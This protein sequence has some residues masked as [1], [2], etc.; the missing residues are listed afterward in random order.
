MVHRL[1]NRM[2]SAFSALLTCLL[3]PACPQSDPQGGTEAGMNGAGGSGGVMVSPVV[4]DCELP[5]PGTSCG[6][7]RHCPGGISAGGS[8][9][10]GEPEVDPVCQAERDPVE[11]CIVGAG[12]AGNPFRFSRSSTTDGGQYGTV[13][14]VVVGENGARSEARHDYED[15]CA[16]VNAELHGPADLSDC[17]DFACVEDRFRGA[18]TQLRCGPEE[19]CGI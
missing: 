12:R 17:S 3:L 4:A 7:L 16:E 15:L 8:S 6:V 18:H 9:S 11:A 1:P 10:G 2:L 5:S 14:Y 19:E 13:V